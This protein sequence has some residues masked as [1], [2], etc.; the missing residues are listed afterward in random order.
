MEIICLSI[1]LSP[2]LHDIW[3]LNSL[4]YLRYIRYDINFIQISVIYENC[5]YFKY[6]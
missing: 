4:E 3:L 6:C 2:K 5:S 1:C